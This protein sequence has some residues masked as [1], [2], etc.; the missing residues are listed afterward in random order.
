MPDFPASRLVDAGTC[1]LAVYEAGEGP[2][3]I[4]LH[5]WPEIAYAWK[6]QLRPLAAAG[7]RAIAVDLKGF[8]AS[9]APADP[10][11]YGAVEMTADFAGLM[12][13]LGLERAVFVGH[14][15]GGA[16]VWRMAQLHP[17]RVAGVVSLC[18]PHVAPAPAPP[19]SI[20]ETRFGMDHYFVR[21]QAP[22]LA[23]AAFSGREEAFVDFMFR[24]PAP[25]D[26][27]PQLIPGVYDLIGKFAAFRGVDPS[28]L[29]LSPADRAVYVQAF[30]TSGFT[31]GINLY[32]NVDRSW[33]QT[34]SIDPII[35][36][37]ALFIGAELDLF[38]PPERA[39]NIAV[40]VPDL[41]SHVL[42]GVGHWLT[43]EAPDAVNRLLLSWLERRIRAFS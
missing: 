42:E 16:L 38:L 21:F 24:G 1:R 33:V 35:R 18:T 23:E 8:G 31:G 11:L 36:A 7:W 37:P 10:D 41:E 4:L 26:R 6:N 30:R 39:A 5:G 3:V 19:I 17:E 13:A 25:R 40:L 28:S 15:W 22:G 34:R 32:R 29:V 14:D 12:D 2:P 27:W 43:W 9:D 20:L